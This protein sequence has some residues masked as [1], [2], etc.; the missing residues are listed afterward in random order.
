MP[1][2]ANEPTCTCGAQLDADHPNQC[3]KCSARSRWQRRHANL[4]RR[5][6]P[7]RKASGRGKDGRRPA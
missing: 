4:A 1:T 6:G 2:P 5:T 3:C 7:G